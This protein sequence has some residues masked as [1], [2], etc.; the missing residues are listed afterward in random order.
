MDSYK[1]ISD[2]E[3]SYIIS[4]A[5]NGERI[6]GRGFKDYREIIIETGFVPKAEGSAKVLLGKTQIIAG[7]KVAIGP[8]YPDTPNAGVITVNAELSPMAAPHFEAGPP[9]EDSVEVARVVDRG[10][11]HS[12]I[13]DKGKLVIIPGEQVFILFIDLYVLGYDGN[14]YDAGEIAA[15]KALC[16][17]KIPKV[18]IVNGQIQVLD[19]WSP[20]EILDYP[21]SITSA[22]VGDAVLVDPNANEER[23][24]ESR[25]T[26][27]LNSKNEL[28]SAQKGGSEA[29]SMDDITKALEIS[30]E[31]A[32]ILRKRIQSIT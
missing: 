9:G 2:I 13:V 25:V 16:N 22:F 32:P 5:K 26:L 20:L 6:D 28:V 23:V 29:F 30:Q 21:I 12:D 31:I 1:I 27:T 15:V 8:P 10:I 24:L 17:T 7:V 14:M 18:E 11:R 4:L 19:E 3:K